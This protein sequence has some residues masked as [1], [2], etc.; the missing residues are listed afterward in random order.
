VHLTFDDECQLRPELPAPTGSV[1]ILI[2][3]GEGGVVPFVHAHVTQQAGPVRT[4]SST[5]QAGR[6]PYHGGP[7]LEIRRGEVLVCKVGASDLAKGTFVI[8]PDRMSATFRSLRDAFLGSLTRIRPAAQ[9]VLDGAFEH[10]KYD[11]ANILARRTY[12]ENNEERRALRF[13]D[14]YRPHERNLLNPDASVSDVKAYITDRMDQQSSDNPCIFAADLVFAACV[15]R[16]M[17]RSA[18][19]DTLIGAIVTY[20][21]SLRDPD[22]PA[23]RRRATDRP[24]AVQRRRSVVAALPA[25]PERTRE[26]AL[27]DVMVQGIDDWEMEPSLDEYSGL[28]L[29]LTSAARLGPESA[30][31]AGRPVAVFSAAF[32]T[33]GRLVS[34]LASNGYFIAARAGATNDL[35]LSAR[36]PGALLSAFAIDTALAS[37]RS[38]A[39]AASDPEIVPIDYAALRARTESHASRLPPS[40]EGLALCDVYQLA[41]TNQLPGLLAAAALV[42]PVAGDAVARFAAFLIPDP[43]IVATPLVVPLVAPIVLGAVAAG[44]GLLAPVLQHP[45]RPSAYHGVSASLMTNPLWGFSPWWSS[46]LFDRFALSAFLST[47][48]ARAWSQSLPRQ[49]PRQGYQATAVQLRDCAGLLCTG[50]LA[51]PD[52]FISRITDSQLKTTVATA[53]FI[54]AIDRSVIGWSVACLALGLR[55]GLDWKQYTDVASV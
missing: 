48:F 38:L 13:T 16:V 41:M 50:N 10:A 45:T 23:Y 7:V 27:L 42:G 30:D 37:V 35:V 49:D 1:T 12:V 26:L 11:F 29:G 25:S 40:H 2:D 15:S 43:A 5:D 4:T 52:A 14:F 8:G 36:G 46:A 54:E 17:E 34:T 21:E 28:M 32:D 31:V 22:R 33:V 20:F 55:P 6:V 39:D 9:A 18:R 3:D 53:D 19:C 24:E 44:G 51:D 47:D